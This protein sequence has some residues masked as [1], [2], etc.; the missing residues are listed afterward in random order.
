MVNKLKRYYLKKHSNEKGYIFP[1]TNFVI[2]LLLLLTFHQINLLQSQKRIHQLNEE[3]YKLEWLYQK[4]YASVLQAKEDPP[5]SYTFPD[6]TIDV[7]VTQNGQNST[8]YQ[9]KMTT[10]TGAYR[11]VN[12]AIPN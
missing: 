11:H 7:I 2:L 5:Y 8:I 1:L 12:I 3:Q 4:T 6:G 9:F 10:D